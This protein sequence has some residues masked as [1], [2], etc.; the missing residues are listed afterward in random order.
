L[1]QERLRAR[2]AERS[3]TALELAMIAGEIGVA[4]VRELYS[5]R[6]QPQRA[7]CL[8]QSNRHAIEKGMRH[9]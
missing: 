7:C 9:A 6:I 2:A 3:Q 5:C 8:Y 4:D 1:R